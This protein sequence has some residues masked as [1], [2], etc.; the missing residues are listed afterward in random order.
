MRDLFETSTGNDPIAAA[1][2]GARPALRQRFYDKAAFEDAGAEYCITVD[3]KPVRTPARRPLAAPTRALAE[4][5]AAEWQAQRDVIDPA[6]MPLTRLANAIIDGVTDSPVAV[7]ADIEKYLASDLLF[8]R[9]H[10][11]A[12]LCA[13]QAQHWDPILAWARDTLG[14]HF[15][16]GEG[17]VH[18]TQPEAALRAAAAAIPADPI[19]ADPIPADS[20]RLGALH[21]VTTLT[22]S[23][24]IA[25][26]LSRG[27]LSAEAA[28]QAAHVDEDW[29]IE[30]WGS[31]ELALARR[32]SRFAEFAAAAM[33]LQSPTV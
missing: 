17:V 15:Q 19:P 29:N 30:K 4:A 7:A 1:R 3:G 12:E 13:R 14:A 22:G 10:A 2:R 18:V 23:A 16:L 6:Q 28:W 25:L 27:V 11:P 33:V 32:A 9:V 20:W 5:L 21:A 31:D 26:A 24:L 8:Y